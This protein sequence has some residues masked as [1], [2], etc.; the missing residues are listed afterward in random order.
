MTRDK[1]LARIEAANPDSEEAVELQSMLVFEELGWEIIY[2]EY[3]IEGDPSFLGRTEQTEIVLTR[4]LVYSLKQ[5]NPDLNDNVLNQA[6]EI[7]RADRSAMSLVGANREVYGYLKNGIPVTYRNEDGNEQ[8]ERVKVI[9]WEN[10]EQNHFLLVS[11]FWVKGSMYRKR[12]D[13]VGFI[14]GIPLLLMELKEPSVGLHHAYN[15]NL[16]DYKDTIPNLLWHNGI[17]LL[18]NARE[19]KAGSLTAEWE[20]FSD[21]KKIN[22]EGEEGRVDLETLIR[23]ICPK[24]RILD[25]LENFVLFTTEHGPLIKQI[26]KNHQ[27]LGVNNAIAS[28]TSVLSQRERK[29]NFTS[30][31]SQGERKNNFTSVLSQEERKNEITP[32]LSQGERKNKFASVPSQ[33]ERNL[34]P[35]FSSEEKENKVHYRGGFE[36]AGLT[37]TARQL[38]KKHTKAEELLWAIL[39]NRQFLNLKFR[40]QHQILNY[41]VDFYCH[42]L[43]LI[44]ECDGKIHDQKDQK[45]KDEFRDNQLK[46][47]GFKILRFSNKEIL[48]ETES[49]LKTIAKIANYDPSP[50]GRRTQVEGATQDEGEGAR[51]LGVFWHTQGTGKSFSMMC[52]SQKVLRKLPGNWTFVIVTDRNELDQQIYEKFAHAGII[53]AK[54]KIHAR[55]I[56]HLRQLL[57]EDHRFVFTLIHKFQTEDGAKHPVLSE[58]DDVIVITDEAHRS[59]YD[60]LAQNM[61]DALPK[62][63]FLGF[64]GTPLIKGEEEKTREV[65]GDYVSVYDFKEAVDDKA[66]V[67]LYYENRL[68]EVQLTAYGEECLNPEMIRIV[69]EAILNPDQEKKLEREFSRM[70]QVI[71]RDDRLEKIA[72]DIVY[73]FVNRGYRGK[74]MYVTIDKATAVK[75]YNRVQAHWQKT[76]NDLKEQIPF[77]EENDLKVLL[78]QIEFMEETDMA[79]VVSSSQN[80]VDDMRNK[81]VDIRPHRKRIVKEDLDVKFKD[82]QDPF[83]LVFVCAMWMT[84]FDVPCCSSIYLD[85]PMRN[86]TLMQTIA[87]ANRVFED[88][89]NGIIVDYVGI[90]RNLEKALAVWGSGRGDTEPIIKNKD[91][92]KSQL[93]MAIDEIRE[94][95]K[96]L[97]VDLE[98]IRRERDVFERTALKDEAVNRI[99]VNDD[100]KKKFLQKAE[101][102]R[103]VYRAYLPDPI[104]PELGETAYIIRKLVKHIRS[105]DPKPDVSDVMQQ[106]EAVLDKSVKGF[107]IR[108]PKGGWQQYDLSTVD[109]EQLKSRYHKG[110]KRIQIEQLRKTIERKLSVMIQVNQIRMNFKE[111]LQEIINEYNHPAVSLDD[112]FEK[113]VNLSQELR[114]EERRYIR[115]ELENEE[116]L[117]VFD[118]LTKPDLDLNGK[119]Q[120]K[121]KAIARQLLQ[122]LKTEKMALDWQ[123]KQQARAG[124]KLSIAEMLDILHP[125]YS[126]DMYF[127]KCDVV[128]QYI[129]DLN[130]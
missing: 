128:Y 40:R 82:P 36:F 92:L 59:Q 116:E 45:E 3:E 77:A 125:P 130:Q 99:L 32:E 44:I 120:K 61:R 13:L 79:V 2:A 39:R 62:A 4:Y 12:P 65:F 64:T 127:Q 55:S 112:V 52:F 124:V 1:I 70:Y 93:I 31:L 107:E 91:E 6:V 22:D 110:K 123:T 111:Q 84:G 81:G 20:H 57:R 73:H 10:P 103:R 129:Y 121:A 102:I 71:T 18:S 95:L 96:P 98:V 66:T 90:F 78:D 42:S 87:R 105:L 85:K 17:I 19:A 16:R 11:Q 126:D 67:P 9:D 34:N 113:L 86:H 68:P 51:R 122:T 89:E 69:D 24:D 74:A 47:V 58:R 7:L 37:E 83:R 38:R 50:R 28:L 15:D 27:Y 8:T 23:A 94:F 101:T 48:E 109:F 60:V 106:V 53:S 26:A 76:I 14:N 108:E 21:W 25:I 56:K 49:V 117:A 119:E 118:L 114:E 5:L 43:K 75:M 88:K 115:E 46:T 29:N 35:A 72:E 63:A 33:G 104:E 100:T 97:K 54:Q 30:V 80:E 41:I